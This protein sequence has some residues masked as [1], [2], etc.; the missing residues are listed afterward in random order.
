MPEMQNNQTA[1][2]VNKQKFK[3]IEQ[4]QPY[5]FTGLAAM[6]MATVCALSGS[7][8]GFWEWVLTVL[9][10]VA[11][12]ESTKS[13]Y[14]PIAYA[15]P[16]EHQ[17]T[18]TGFAETDT[19]LKKA[20]TELRNIRNSS[21]LIA[22]KDPAFAAKL[23]DLTDAAYRLVDYAAGNPDRVNQMRR[24]FNYYI[25]TLEKLSGTY[26]SLEKGD[27]SSENVKQT[28][29]QIVAAADAMDEFFKKQYDKMYNDTALDITTDVDVLE[30]MLAA[31]GIRTRI[32]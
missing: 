12:Y 17:L 9:V 21:D 32:N 24:V 15:I 7:G 30:S 13:K 11:V 8:I 6:A 19:I 10:S 1:V 26:V 5:I 31:D 18:L 4:P 25:P 16:K 2:T 14:R 22:K 28:R 29:E 23:I 27:S 20:D 3:K